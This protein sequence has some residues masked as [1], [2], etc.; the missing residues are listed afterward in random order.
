M[1]AMHAYMPQ[2]N[3]RLW[4]GL[5]ITV[6][7]TCHVGCAGGKKGGQAVKWVSPRARARCEEDS[8]VALF[9]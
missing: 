5:A 2:L 9:N 8:P 6:L 4:D 1:S 7:S 3:A